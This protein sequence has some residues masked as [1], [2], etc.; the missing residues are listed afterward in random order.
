MLPPI[1]AKEA[2]PTLKRAPED[3]LRVVLEVGHLQDKLPERLGALN[4]FAPMG[5]GE[6]VLFP[7]VTEPAGER[8]RVV[9]PTPITRTSTSW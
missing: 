6:L 3:G 2:P 5:E 4:V 1:E 7:L 9:P 8:V